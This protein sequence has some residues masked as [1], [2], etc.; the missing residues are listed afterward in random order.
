M[1]R[2]ALLWYA[3]VRG[4][5]GWEEGLGQLLL[6]TFAIVQPTYLDHFYYVSSYG[7]QVSSVVCDLCELG[8][9]STMIWTLYV[10]VERNEAWI[11]VASMLKS[12]AFL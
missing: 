5:S 3:T 8:D 2:Y 7:S 11:L 9:V 1:L 6:S 12:E 4:T 10:E